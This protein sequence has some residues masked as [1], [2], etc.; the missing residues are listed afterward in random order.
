MSYQK[1]RPF[2]LQQNATLKLSTFSEELILEPLPISE[3]M[4]PRFTKQ[5]SSMNESSS[6]LAADYS[7]SF[8]K[9]QVELDQASLILFRR[10]L[11]S[12]TIQILCFCYCRGGPERKWARSIAI[13]NRQPSEDRHESGVL[14]RQWLSLR[15]ASHLLSLSFILSTCY[16][17]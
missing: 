17:F 12:A 1:F 3:W 14:R 16:S 5:K 2:S 11:Q 8:S 7:K 13:V 9:A 4:H 15:W 6:I 10:Q